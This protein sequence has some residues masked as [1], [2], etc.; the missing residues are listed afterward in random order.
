MTQ[1]APLLLLGLLA[2]GA[3]GRAVQAPGERPA[4]GG[5]VA[6]G[7]PDLALPGTPPAAGASA[8]SS[9]QDAA[10]AAPDREL[11]ARVAAARSADP[12][13]AGGLALV[14]AWSDAGELEAARLLGASLLA[15]D[16]LSAW[17]ER[18]AAGDS[19]AARAALGVLEPALDWLGLA[20]R[21]RVERAHVRFALGVLEARAGEPARAA[22]AFELA[23]AE[24][25][26][27]ELRRDAVYDLATLELLEGE[28]WRASLPELGGGA[29][30]PP[31][32]TAPGAEEE[33][34][35]PL[36][37]ARRHYLAAR[38]R[39]VE[40]LRLDPAMEDLRADA[41][42]CLRRLRE[43]DEL[44][45]QRQEQQDQDQDQQDQQEQDQQD[46]EQDQ[47]D[48]QQDQQDQQD[49][50]QPQEQD[51]EPQEPE[52]SEQDQEERE[53]DEE[54]DQQDESEEAPEPREERYLTREEVQRLLDRL[55]EHERQGE[56]LRE[57]MRQARRR[58]SARDW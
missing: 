53:E 40:G 39:L 8:A 58:P 26:P 7:P 36:E 11:V 54:Q 34:P 33:P 5:P 48:Q 2:L 25:G 1:G 14:E 42:L 51:P 4:P 31:A 12:S 38:E 32:A 16:P 29:P 52:D 30:T 24:A 10:P 55:E 20:G 13:L 18:V 23:R 6:P 3:A 41:E 28:R 27:G 37:E 56:E 19:R 46:Q 47:Q 43:L 9:A 49:Q 45:R 22:E 35:D 50:Q 17:R 57:R 44:E 15:P 21:T